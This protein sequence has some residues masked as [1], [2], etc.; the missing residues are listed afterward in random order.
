LRQHSHQCEAPSPDF[1]PIRRSSMPD[2]REDRSRAVSETD[3]PSQEPLPE[4]KKSNSVES[5]SS[6]RYLSALDSDHRPRPE[7]A[8]TL[9]PTV[10]PRLDLPSALQ[11][12]FRKKLEQSKLSAS[13]GGSQP[14]KAFKSPSPDSST[15]TTSPTPTSL[16]P[17]SLSPASSN[18]SCNSTVSPDIPPVPPRSRSDTTV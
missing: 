6:K 18:H 16:T 3:A 7:G 1:Q 8:E 14:L 17:K 5:V 2:L 13:E 4:L 15:G 10:P 12:S 9:P 11:S